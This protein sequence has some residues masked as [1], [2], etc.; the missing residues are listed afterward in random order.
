LDG[1]TKQTQ[2]EPDSDDLEK[3][4]LPRIQGGT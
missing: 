2:I 1:D 4:N 3:D